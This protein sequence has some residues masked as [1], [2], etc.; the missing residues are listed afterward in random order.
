MRRIAQFLQKAPWVVTSAR[1]IW[2][3]GQAKFTAGVVGVVF[4]AQGQVLL[5]E[6]V[7]HPYAPWGLPGGWVDRRESPFETVSRELQ[8]ELQ[9]TVNVGELLLA[10]VDFG[11]HLDFAYLCEAKDEVGRLSSELLDYAWYDVDALPK[12]QR[13]HY[14]AI[15]R[16]KEL[17]AKEQVTGVL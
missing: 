9:L 2:R 5:V 11:D 6:H 13:F 3:I 7:F 10:E 12:L 1:L 8:E 17:K 4:N 16:A 14:R 15:Q